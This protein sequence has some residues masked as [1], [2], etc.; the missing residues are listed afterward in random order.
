MTDNIETEQQKG[1]DETAPGGDP[2]R[3]WTRTD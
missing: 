2:V 1:Q 3:K